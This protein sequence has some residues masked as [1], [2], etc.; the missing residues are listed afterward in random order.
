MK[1]L[2]DKVN[3]AQAYRNW[4]NG[5]VSTPVR[6]LRRQEAR[7]ARQAQQATEEGL[8]D[9]DFGY[10]STQNT[11]SMSRNRQR[12]YASRERRIRTK[13]IHGLLRKRTASGA[14]WNETRAHL[15][16]SL[17]RWSFKMALY[18]VEE[19]PMFDAEGAA[20]HAQAWSG[21]ALSPVGDNRIEYYVKDDRLVAGE[22]TT[23]T[24]A[25]LRKAADERVHGLIRQANGKPLSET[26]M[27]KVRAVS[28]A[29]ARGYKLWVTWDSND[30]EAHDDEARRHCMAQ[31]AAILKALPVGHYEVR[32]L[33]TFDW[34]R[35]SCWVKQDTRPAKPAP[36]HCHRC[37][38]HLRIMHPTLILHPA[39]STLAG[40]L[41]ACNQR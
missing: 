26:L 13:A 4:G 19:H 27:R 18:S 36:G 23:P 32:E 28:A 22:R 39:A 8:Y 12:G 31:Q 29:Y 35:R 34:A 3:A 7:E 9:A 20:Y 5:R 38:E 17:D 37:G 1:T 10:G 25:A 40:T 15:Q 16:R 41:A 24:A 11:Q 30:D 6:D 33:F 21:G 2:A 14:S